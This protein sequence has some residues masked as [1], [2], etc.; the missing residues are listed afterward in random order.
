M[1]KIMSN[2]KISPKKIDC[3][4]PGDTCNFEVRALTYNLSWASQKKAI[5]GSEADFVETCINKKIDCYKEALKHIKFLHFSYN[6]DVIGIQEV[7]DPNLVTSI[8]KNTGL[9]G[10]YRG[11]T[12]HSKE[13]IYSGCAIMWNTQTLGT[14]VTG[15]TINLA[16]VDKDA[17]TCIII[18]TSKNINLIVAHF[19]W[20]TTR[21]DV[22]AVT[23]IINAHITSDGPIIILADTND[24]HTFI[25]NLTPLIIKNKPLSHGLSKFDARERLKSCCWHKLGHKYLNFNDTGDYILSENVKHIEIAT[26]HPSNDDKEMALYSDHMPVAATII[27]PYNREKT[28]SSTRK[29]IRK[30]K[31]ASLTRTRTRNNTRKLRAASASF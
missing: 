27:L 19:P 11:A 23:D 15:K 13:K 20:L 16:P 31:S 21:L 29:S 4:Q 30:I 12:W 14:M 25:T 9:D 6:F 18:T 28:S 26:Y 7:E 22:K 8:C 3:K 2:M 10:W 17:R 5:A 1:S 24:F